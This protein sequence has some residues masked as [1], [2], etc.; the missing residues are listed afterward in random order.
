MAGKV[1]VT[2][3]PNCGAPVDRAVVDAAD[4]RCHY[5]DHA[6]PTQ[7]DPPPTPPPFVLFQAGTGS[8]QPT[9]GGRSTGTVVRVV[10]G[11]AP[12][13]SGWRLP[14]LRSVAG[15]RPGRGRAVR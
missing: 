5:C 2:E 12:Q 10:I 8:Y 7:D 9:R 11:G 3:C 15:S 4:P 13:W 1:A 6:L 14:W